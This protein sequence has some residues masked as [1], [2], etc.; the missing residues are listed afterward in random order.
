[1]EELQAHL[2]TE[3]LIHPPASQ[4]QQGTMPTWILKL[5]G[6]DFQLAMEQARV[7]MPWAT[8]NTLPVPKLF[9][10]IQ[11]Q[12]GNVVKQSW[13]TFK[14]RFS[15]TAAKPRVEEDTYEP[16]PSTAQSQQLLSSEMGHLFAALRVKYEDDD[17]SLLQ[18]AIQEVIDRAITSYMNIDESMPLQELLT[19]TRVHDSFRALGAD[20]LHDL[21]S[22][23]LYV[24]QR[25]NVRHL[26]NPGV[27]SLHKL[28]AAIEA[29]ARASAITPARVS[30]TDRVVELPPPPARVSPTDRVVELPPPPARVSPTDPAIDQPTSIAS[31]HARSSVPS[32]ASNASSP[33]LH[34]SPTSNASS[35]MLHTSPASNA[36]SPML[37]TSPASNASSRARSSVDSPASRVSSRTSTMSR[38]SSRSMNENTGIRDPPE[39][40][41][42]RMQHVN[43]DDSWIRMEDIYPAGDRIV[44]RPRTPSPPSPAFQME[45]IYPE[46]GFPDQ[47]HTEDD[48]DSSPEDEEATVVVGTK[49]LT[50]W[51][52]LIALLF[53]AGLV[54]VGI[55]QKQS[56]GLSFRGGILNF[57]TDSEV[58]H[59]DLQHITRPWIDRPA[60]IL[61]AVPLPPP[62]RSP[63]STT[64]RRRVRATPTSTQQSIHSRVAPPIASRLTK[65]LHTPPPHQLPKLVRSAQTWFAQLK[66]EAA[67]RLT[68]WLSENSPLTDELI[69][70]IR[71]NSTQFRPTV[72]PQAQERVH[73]Q[74]SAFPL[75]IAEDS[76]VH[77]VSW[78][79]VHAPAD[80][81]LDLDIR[82]GTG[83]APVY[84]PLLGPELLD[85][86]AG[87]GLAPV[88]EPLVVSAPAI[89]EWEGSR[90]TN[91]ASELTG[92]PLDRASDNRAAAVAPRSRKHLRE[93]LAH[94]IPKVDVATKAYFLHMA[95]T[96]VSDVV[97]G[98]QTW[99]QS[100]AP[101]PE[102]VYQALRAISE[103]AQTVYLVSAVALAV[104][105]CL[106]IRDRM[107]E[108]IGF[109]PLMAA[110]GAVQA[111]ETAISGLVTLMAME[112]VHFAALATPEAI[113]P[114]R[115]GKFFNRLTYD[116]RKY[117]PDPYQHRWLPR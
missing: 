100:A 96:M 93:A 4:L 99:M 113:H 82:A 2:H 17:I 88:Y 43:P 18:R 67:G 60:A 46:T 25:L 108:W 86:R 22:K 62:R 115:N 105:D 103:P 48:E 70:E 106:G 6:K 3:E 38:R 27:N 84:E 109:R 76:A 14:S 23:L 97:E 50:L 111:V 30:P 28:R 81:P 92:R 80:R 42:Y 54:A 73:Q 19:S 36:S 58:L 52:V 11:R 89:F 29:K 8:T 112:G 63:P 31:S 98:A 24:L 45:D 1:V 7:N 32:P 40:K 110:A 79:F 65:L 77:I 75:F 69:Q 37:H 41:P 34:A 72:P 44:G 59:V 16:G 101:K 57:T 13:N 83:P 74:P 94:S 91:V 15:R 12:I 104:G 49:R 9:S 87:T 95:T 71:H 102:Q 64:Q 21:T 90:L 56:V 39:H 78:D 61:P 33:M 51:S 26:N 66:P 85:I 107:A 68:H 53:Y 117:Y 5:H 10:T 114:L 20:E 55:P 47:P 116:E 35:P